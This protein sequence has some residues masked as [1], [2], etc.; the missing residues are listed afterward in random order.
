[1]FSVDFHGME[2]GKL[3]CQGL[4]HQPDATPLSWRHLRNAVC[5]SFS[6]RE[7]CT[8]AFVMSECVINSLSE[9]MFL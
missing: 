7:K 6:K 8:F 5:L 3:E 9:I 1:M 4:N 2:K